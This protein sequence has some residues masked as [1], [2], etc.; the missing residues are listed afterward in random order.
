MKIEL[1][2]LGKTKDKFL[3]EGVDE[4]KKRLSH[5]TTVSVKV[6]KNKAKSKTNDELMKVMEGE[7]LL[8][9]VIKGSY[10]VALDS[11]GKQYSSKEISGLIDKW[12]QQGVRLVTFLIGGPVGRDTCC[13]CPIHM[14]KYSNRRPFKEL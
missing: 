7:I 3:V 12:E 10:I 4:Y 14:V 9:N 11:S 13:L 8:S 5:Y 2:F 1:L 6:I